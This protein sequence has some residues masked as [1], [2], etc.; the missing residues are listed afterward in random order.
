MNAQIISNPSNQSS[1]PSQTPSSDEISV[2]S[3]HSAPCSSKPRGKI[4]SLPSD[5]RVLI[6]RMLDN[7]ATYATVAA[8]LA[9]HGVSL[10]GQNLSN[11]YHSG[12]Q[13]YH[14][15]QE[16]LTQLTLLQENAADLPEPANLP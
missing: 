9:K 3:R 11:W 6:N 15:R 4:A 12:F 5:K 8:E 7:G 10:N 14:C 1:Q 16:W 13:D 2:H